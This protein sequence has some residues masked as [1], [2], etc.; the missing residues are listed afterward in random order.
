MD[1]MQLAKRHGL[2]EHC[3][4]HGFQKSLGRHLSG[5]RHDRH[6]WL[7]RDYRHFHGLGRQYL[8]VGWEMHRSCSD[9]HVF[10]QRLYVL[11]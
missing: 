10:L 8:L 11:R 7:H 4:V 2:A 6:R 5:N 1:V 9:G 3:H